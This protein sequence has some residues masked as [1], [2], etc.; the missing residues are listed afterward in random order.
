VNA[1]NLGEMI[2]PSWLG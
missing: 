1:E 2:N